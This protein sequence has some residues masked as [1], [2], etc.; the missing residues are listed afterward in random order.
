MFIEAAAPAPGGGGTNDP[1]AAWSWLSE[2]TRKFAEVTRR[3]PALRPLSTTN[4]SPARGPR[5]TSRGSRY[6]WPWST[7]T[8]L[9]VPVWNTPEAGIANWRPSGIF[10]LDVDEHARGQLQAG[11]V[12]NQPHLD[13]ACAHVDFGID[14]IHAAAEGA[15]RVG[16]RRDRSGVANLDLSHVGL[17]DL[18]L[19]S[20]AQPCRAFQPHS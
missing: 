17:E 18:R 15:A 16:V 7:K 19:V 3:S 20:S 11:I 1:R 9:R 4:S 12:E 5:V 13:G 8:M 2:S 6:P 14:E 10:K